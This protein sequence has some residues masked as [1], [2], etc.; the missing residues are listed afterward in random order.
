[1]IGITIRPIRAQQL[2]VTLGGQPFVI[3]LYQHTTG[4]YMD[5]SVNGADLLN[6]VICQNYNRIVRYPVL[7][8]KGDLFFIDTQGNDDPHYSGLG[9]RFKL[10]YKSDEQFL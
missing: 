8:F 6:G 5:L 4:L 9:T 10:I 2:E 3:R 7:K 1:M